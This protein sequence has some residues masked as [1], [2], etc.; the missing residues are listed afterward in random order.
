[1]APLDER[2]FLQLLDVERSQ[3]RYLGG[4]ATLTPITI[5][6]VQISACMVTNLAKRKRAQF[7]SR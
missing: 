7:I 1:M 5:A 6:I 2:L 3:S 4:P